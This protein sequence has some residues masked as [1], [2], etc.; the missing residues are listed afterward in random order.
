[1][2]KPTKSATV[3]LFPLCKRSRARILDCRRSDAAIL[4]LA[5]GAW[6][7]GVIFDT[8]KYKGDVWLQIQDP[9]SNDVNNEFR[10]DLIITASSLTPWLGYSCAG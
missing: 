1:M 5:H 10:S 7:L 9:F 8:S 4:A 3:M 6:A 2:D